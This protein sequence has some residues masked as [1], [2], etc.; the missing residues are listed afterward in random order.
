MTI[1]LRV[2]AD[3]TAM[4]ECAYLSN[5]RLSERLFVGDYVQTEDGTAIIKEVIL[6]KKFDTLYCNAILD[7]P[8]EQPDINDITNNPGKD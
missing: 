3:F 1:I 8:T 7:Q 6:L 5:D 4:A 2:F